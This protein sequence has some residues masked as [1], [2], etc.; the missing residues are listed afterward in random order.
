MAVDASGDTVLAEGRPV[1]SNVEWLGPIA[2]RVLE[3]RAGHGLPCP[4]AAEIFTPRQQRV[5]HE[6]VGNDDAQP[7]T[8]LAIGLQQRLGGGQSGLP[9]GF[10]G[11]RQ[12]NVG[13]MTTGRSAPGLSFENNPLRVNKEDQAIKPRK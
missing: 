5:S 13:R 8:P 12:G 6:M 9:V 11:C 7:R 2:K 10:A 4:V 1:K 3:Q